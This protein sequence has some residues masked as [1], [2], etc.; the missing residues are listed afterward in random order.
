MEVFKDI[1]KECRPD[2][3]INDEFQEVFRGT[4]NISVLDKTDF[5]PTFVEY[6]NQKKLWKNQFNNSSYYSVSLFT[7]L[8]KLKE[9]TKMI[10]RIKSY[11][12]GFTTIKRGISILNSDSH[13]DYFLYDYDNN[14]PYLDFVIIEVK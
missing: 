7:S 4:S 2:L 8:D 12:K 1:P 3:A 5:L 14:N 9:K 6:R 10:K 13:I 11:S